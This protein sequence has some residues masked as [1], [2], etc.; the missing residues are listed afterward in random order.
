MPPNTQT[1]SNEKMPPSELYKPD[2]ENAFLLY[3]TFCGDA[4]RTAAALDMDEDVVRA[5]ATENG[6]DK[7]LKPIIDL[8]NSTRAGDVERAIN[9]AIN[10]VDAHKLR[11]FLGRVLREMTGMNFTD[12][13]AFLFPEASE[14]G[15]GGMVKVKKFSTRSLADLAAAIEKCQTLTYIALNDSATERRERK[16]D[17]SEDE[18]TASQLHVK[19]AEAMAN[20][21][22]GSK[23]LRGLVL[24]AQAELANE[25][26]EIEVK[27]TDGNIRDSAFTAP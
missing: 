13:R 19:L 23:S 25:H 21:T 3:A 11:L 6:W 9:R 5:L 17:G 15:S 14:P 8:K 7:K 2:K 26:S 16:D 1:E 10:F 24:D 22:E 18:A 27:A 12:L 20:A 4:A